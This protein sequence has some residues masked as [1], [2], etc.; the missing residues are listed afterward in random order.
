MTN[1]SQGVVS[2]NNNDDIHVQ[3][4]ACQLP[5]DDAAGQ[6]NLMINNLPSPSKDMATGS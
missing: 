4:L 6:L 5:V 1:A 2:V 3:C